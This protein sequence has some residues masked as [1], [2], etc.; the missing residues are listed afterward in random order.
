MANQAYPGG[1][2]TYCVGSCATAYYPE[3]G[4][5]CYGPGIIPPLSLYPRMHLMPSGLIACVGSGV[6]DRVYDPNTGKWLWTG[7][8][9]QRHYGTSV[10][11]PLQNADTEKGS[12]FPKWLPF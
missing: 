6:D 1:T 7:K 4:S 8:T 9:M 10:L 5:P 11:L 3:A 2:G 12:S